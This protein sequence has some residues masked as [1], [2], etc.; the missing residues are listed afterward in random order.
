MHNEE[1]KQTIFHQ[2]M[3]SKGGQTREQETLFPS[4]RWPNQGFRKVPIRMKDLRIVAENLLCNIAV[5]M[6]KRWLQ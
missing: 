5:S 1:Y 6:V 4:Q 2:V 3:F